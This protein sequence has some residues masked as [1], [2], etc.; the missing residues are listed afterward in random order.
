MEQKCKMCMQFFVGNHYR[1]IKADGSVLEFQ[2]I[3]GDPPN[4]FLRSGG[5]MTLEN[6]IANFIEVHQID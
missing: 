3:G 4:V 1:V 5:T 2:F 6:A